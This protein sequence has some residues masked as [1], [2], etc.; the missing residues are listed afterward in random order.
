VDG[1]RR[2]LDPQNTVQPFLFSAASNTCW[3]STMQRRKLGS[4]SAARRSRPSSADFGGKNINSRNNKPTSKFVGILSILAAASVCA[5]VVSTSTAY[6][7]ARAETRDP[8]PASP[9]RLPSVRSRTGVAVGVPSSD[10]AAID[11][12][13]YS[14]EFVTPCGSDSPHSR[15]RRHTVGRPF[16]INGASS[17]SFR[18]QD[19]KKEEDNARLNSFS[20]IYKN[21]VWG[22]EGGSG[23]GSLMSSTE[24]VR[25]TLDLV[26]DRVKS[27]LGVER[28]RLLDLPVGDFVWM[29]HWLANR[30]DVNYMGMDIVPH[31]IEEHS[32]EFKDRHD[33]AFQHHDIVKDPL[34]ADYDVIFSR[35]MTQHLQTVDTLSVLRHFSAS[36]KYLLISNYPNVTVN[37]VLP[38]NRWRYRPQ[39]LNLAPFSLTDPLC[40][41]DDG[42]GCISSLFKLPLLQWE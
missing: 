35:Q 36:G 15:K 34:S 6:S 18:Q 23:T 37:K 24:N 7:R 8:P 3:L 12:S 31:L 10:A 4:A 16:T 13:R 38:T 1:R 30:T 42:G 39:N 25:K 11:L 28:V 26:V 32:D 14:P 20:D 22:G 5:L 9:Q 29:R 27:E 40:E 41:D 33:W 2:T 21:D 17:S 19:N